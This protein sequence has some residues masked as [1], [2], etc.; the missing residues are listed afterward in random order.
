MDDVP[1]IG[2]LGLA[3]VRT[4]EDL[5]AKLQTVRRLADNPSLRTLETKTK[6][7]ETP[8]SKTTVGEM[9]KGVRFPSRAVM[10]SFLRACGV[11]KDAMEPW[12]RAWTRIVSSAQEPAPGG[13]PSADEQ[14]QIGELQSQVSQLLAENEK[15]RLQLTNSSSPQVA[16]A[17]DP[18][19]NV[20]VPAQGHVVRY[21]SIDD[22]PSE[23]LFYGELEKYIKNAKEE[24]YILGKGFHDEQSSSIYES[25]IRAEEEA[26]RRRVDLIRIQTGNPVAASWA[27]GYAR[28]LEDYPGNFRM[29]A[30]LDGVSYNDV[31]LIDPHGRDPVVSFLFETS[32]RRRLG[33]VGRPV[34][35]LFITNARALARNLAEQL[36]ARA[37]NVSK[38]DSQLVREMAVNY[39]YFA[40]GVHMASSKIKRDVPYAYPLG[41]KAILHKWRRDIKG[42]LS[43]PANRATIQYTGEEQ[44]SFDGVAYELSWS[45]KARM[46]RLELRAYEAVNVT[47]KHN[48]RDRPAFTYIPLP[49]ATKKDKLEVGSWIDLVVEGARENQ[50][51]GLLAELRDGGAPIDAI[52]V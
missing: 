29:R 7:D 36:A 46:D 13:P 24:V 40:W 28:L 20:Y 39:T 18:A 44:D 45:G 43:G 32:E 48:G 11:P 3:T 1:D 30:D 16:A 37:D 4:P 6:H 49:E 50:M 23:Q 51:T 31:I 52:R 35:A 10:V 38:L 9:L 17:R 47:I 12:V 27:D 8:L 41:G 5:V 22:E 26:L 25:L 34:L 33:P 19:V 21:F 2:D 14:T 42:M 15:L